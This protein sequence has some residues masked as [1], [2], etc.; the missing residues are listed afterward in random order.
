[1]SVQ[2]I[3]AKRALRILDALGAKYDISLPDG[4]KFKRVRKN[5]DRQHDFTTTG[6]NEKI[7]LL[8]VGSS[9]KI[10]FNGFRPEALRGAIAAKANQKF[11]KAAC[12]THIDKASGHIEILRVR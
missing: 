7:P 9:E 1:M 8:K 5:A 3:A 10:P 2:E 4:T 6:Y 11:G 12:I